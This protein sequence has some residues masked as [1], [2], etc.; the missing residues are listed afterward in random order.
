MAVVD[1]QQSDLSE[2]YRWIPWIFVGFFLVVFTVNGIFVYFAT[3]SWVGLVTENPYD[4]G[5][6]YNEILAAKA[7]QEQLGWTHGL[8]F[9]RTGQ[10]DLGVTGILTLSLKGRDGTGL[11]GAT[12]K[13]VAERPG[14]YSQAFALYLDQAGDGRY[15]ASVEL[16][17]PGQWQVRLAAQK[18]EDSYRSAET[19]YVE[20]PKL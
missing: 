18:G 12:V 20:P 11:N 8:S 2:R 3:T 16:P 14:R 13:V 7:A 10:V 4:R 9:E 17:L 15:A 19:L 1:N 5:L 6:N